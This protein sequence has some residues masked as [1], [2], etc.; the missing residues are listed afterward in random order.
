M[1]QIVDY[2]ERTNADGE[3]FYALIL[4]GGLDMVKSQDTANYYAT[5]RAASVTST[6]DEE[7]YK[8]LIGQEIP[9][10]VQRIPCEPFEFTVE[11]TG[12]VL[13]LE[14]RW[15]Y[16]KEGDTIEEIVFEG[17]PVGAEAL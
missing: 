7:T 5:S 15:S 1:V 10:S 4:Q 8:G 14:H 13:T 3:K 2:K 12:E 11:E 17:E 16:L 6:F 9:G